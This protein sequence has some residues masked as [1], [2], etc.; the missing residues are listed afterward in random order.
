LHPATVGAYIYL[1]PLFASVLSLFYGQESW[2]IHMLLGGAAIFA[3][4]YFVSFY[5]RK[6]KS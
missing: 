3:G 6:F 4:V 2:S 5:G 1:Q